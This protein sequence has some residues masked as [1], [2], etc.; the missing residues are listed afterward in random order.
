MIDESSV[1]PLSPP[2][3]RWSLPTWTPSPALRT[4]G[5]VLCSLFSSGVTVLAIW[6]VA[7]AAM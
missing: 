5:K 7:K 1:H 2:P 3:P 6:F 4:V